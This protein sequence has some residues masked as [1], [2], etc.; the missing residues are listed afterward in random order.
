MNNMYIYFELICFRLAFQEADTNKDGY[1]S[2][3]EY[4]RTAIIVSVIGTSAPKSDGPTEMRVAYD[5]I[6]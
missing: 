6:S 5:R 1:L 4:M 3:D 2:T